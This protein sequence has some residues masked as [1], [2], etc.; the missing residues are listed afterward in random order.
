MTLPDTEDGTF[1]ILY[2]WGTLPPESGKLAA[3]QLAKELIKECNGEPC[4]LPKG[5]TRVTRQGVTI[6]KGQVRMPAG[7]IKTIGE[8]PVTIA[9]H[10]DVAAHIT[11]SVQAE[12]IVQV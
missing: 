9:L 4:V 2:T 3:A 11:V 5:T 1:S 10:T 7:P 6:E 12:T 8:H